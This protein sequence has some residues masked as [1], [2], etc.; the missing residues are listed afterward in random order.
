MTVCLLITDLNVGGAERALTYLARGLPK[1]RWKVHV[2]NLGGEEPL[3]DSLR[4]EGIDVRCL[5]VSKRRP[6]QAIRGLAA[7]LREIR[8]QLLQCFMFH[9]NVAGRFAA[10]LAG[11][12]WVLGGLRVAE[13][14]K[15]WHLTVDRVTAWMSA[16]SVCVSAGVKRFSITYGGLSEARLTVIPNGVDVGPF[17]R[18]KSLD[19]SSL[20]FDPAD[21]LALFVGRLD[22]QK[23]LPYLLDAVEL[24][25]SSRPRWKLVMTG[26]EGTESEWFRERVAE[27][28]VLSRHVKW[29]GFCEDIPELMK[30]SE[31][32]LLPSLWE[33]MPNVVLEAMAAGRAVIGTDVEGTDELVVPGETGWLVPPANTEAL[34]AAM[35]EAFDKPDRTK[36]YGEA[37][38]KRVESRFTLNGTIRAYEKLWAG[39]LGLKLS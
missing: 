12:P 39:V 26:R 35:A 32:L 4:A 16:G 8:P 25:A 31:I 38:R 17:D 29:L 37:G 6:I 15:G 14:Q 20:G 33:G 28:P 7:V 27:S 21:R 3:A 1:N 24:V 2:V 10:R 11:V 19:K 9:S 30:T 34:A 18:A 22:P 23:G 5:G 13:H 36:K